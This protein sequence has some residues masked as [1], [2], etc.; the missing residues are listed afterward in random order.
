MSSSK[1]VLC[2]VLAALVCGCDGGDDATSGSADAAGEPV[3]EGKTTTTMPSG[4]VVS[5]KYAYPLSS[6][7]VRP[8]PYKRLSAR[9]GAEP[10]GT[11]AV[12]WP[13][14]SGSPEDEVMR[15]EANVRGGRLTMTL[16][17]EVTSN[18]R[19]LKGGRWGD[20]GPDLELDDY[21]LEPAGEMGSV[22]YSFI[23]ENDEE[24]LVLAEEFLRKIVVPK[25]I[26][27]DL[28]DRRK[29]AGKLHKQVEQ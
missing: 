9:T 19:V 5:C 13:G 21:F 14:E 3:F 11:I 17:C 6:F 29:R 28:Y 2:V 22:L 25:Q 4:A 27:S 23:A 7:Q 10:V 16:T 8:S 24:A 18:Y 26:G 20:G 15:R 1:P 12:L